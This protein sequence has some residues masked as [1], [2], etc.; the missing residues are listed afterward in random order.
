MRAKEISQQLAHRVEEVTRYLLPNGKKEA[1]EWRV[2]I[3][4][5][6]KISEAIKEA[7][8]YLGIAMPQFVAHKPPK[9]IKP[10][11]KNVSAINPTSPVLN[12]LTKERKL[13]VETIN[14]WV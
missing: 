5:N 4:R 8:H 3:Q 12:Y 14:A 13:T 2:G 11:L 6:L 10:R 1:Y 9:F 7:C